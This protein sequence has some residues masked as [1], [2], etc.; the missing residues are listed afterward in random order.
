MKRTSFNDGW[1]VRPKISS[2]LE[3]RGQMPSWTPVRLPHDA[4]I[5]STRGASEGPG[6]AYFPGG[7]W[8]Y[9]KHFAVPDDARGKRMFVEFEGVYRDAAVWVNGSFAG[10]HPYGYTGFALAIDHLVRHGDDNEI[11]V[12]VTTQEDARWYSGAGIYRNVKLV[13]GELVHLALDSLFVTTPELD[14]E[15][16]VVQVS[17]VLENDGAVTTPTSVHTE[18]VDDRG[19]VVATEVTP[20]TSFPRRS[21]TIRQRLVVRDPRRWSID[22]PSLY[23]CRVIVARP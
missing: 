11:R 13:V 8:E 14:D 15:I 5:G 16:A 7:T 17:A 21:A 2:F 6:N 12:E 23:V 20:L 10:H 4:M 3:R 1:S 18:I 9:Q 19:V 22:T